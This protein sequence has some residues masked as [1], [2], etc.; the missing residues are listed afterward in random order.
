M[1]K[2]LMHDPI[3]LSFNYTNTYKT[4]YD[5]GTKTIK[6]H[7]IHGIAKKESG[8]GNIH[9]SGIKARYVAHLLVFSAMLKKNF[10]T[11]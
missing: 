5:D 3:F 6:Y 10:D 4:L 1:I 7:H 8:Y 2:E 9:K 11:N